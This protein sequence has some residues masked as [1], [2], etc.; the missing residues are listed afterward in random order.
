MGKAIEINEAN[1]GTEV[2]QSDVPVLI[3]FWATWC[4]Y[5]MMISDS[6]DE[7]AEEYSG[8]V[9]VCKVN[10]DENAAL[11]RKHKILSLPTLLVYK[12]GAVVNQRPGGG[13]KPDIE[14]LFKDFV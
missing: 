13:S 12:D 11:A 1:F 8:R 5:C 3:D 7:L 10:F 4:S 9:K 6:I 2:L 14:A